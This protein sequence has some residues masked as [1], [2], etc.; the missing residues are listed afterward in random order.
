MRSC[1]CSDKARCAFCRIEAR[2]RRGDW[3]WRGDRAPRRRTLGVFSGRVSLDGVTI[4][5]FAGPGPVTLARPSVPGAEVTY[6]LAE[7]DGALVAERVK[8]RAA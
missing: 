4:V 3:R 7:I 1:R 2:E 6:S 8:E 5:P